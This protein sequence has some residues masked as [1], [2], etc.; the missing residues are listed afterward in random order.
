[1]TNYSHYLVL[2]LTTTIILLGSCN[3]DKVERIPGDYVAYYGLDGNA[4]DGSEYEN[5]GEVFGSVYPVVDRNGTE[6]GAMFFE[7]SQ[8][9][10][11]VGDSEELKITRAISISTWVRAE[12]TQRGWNTIVNKWNGLRSED[13]YYLG[14]NSDGMVLRWNI[15]YENVEVSTPFPTESW[16]HVVATYDG[17]EL[18]IFMDGKMVSSKKYE[19]RID[20]HSAP[21]TLGTQSQ[22]SFGHTNFHGAIDDVYVY[23]RALT[24]DEVMRLYLEN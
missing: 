11:E 13:G 4:E 22:R 3:K 7:E 23:D 17:F 18:K 6:S 12:A 14:I 8:G 19:G 15:S 20:D 1:M 21:F 10:I 5:H 2:A 9:Y 16:V 24:D